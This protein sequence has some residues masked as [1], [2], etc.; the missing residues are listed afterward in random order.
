MKGGC[1]HTNTHIQYNTIKKNK[2]TQKM[3]KHSYKIN[4][5]KTRLLFAFLQGERR[6]KQRVKR[7]KKKY[8]TLT[9]ARTQFIRVL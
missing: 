4:N 9:V 8:S 5:Y 6:L 3:L 7:K 1:P 2:R